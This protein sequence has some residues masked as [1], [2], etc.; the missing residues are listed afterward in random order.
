MT[1]FQN[2]HTKEEVFGDLSEDFLGTI[3]VR[4]SY[5]G[6]TEHTFGRTLLDPYKMVSKDANGDFRPL[7]KYLKTTYYSVHLLGYTYNI[8]VFPFSSQDGVAMKCAETA[9]YELCDYASA[10]SALY[11][12]VLPSDIQNTLEQRVPERIL[13]SRGLYCNDIS[14]ILKNFGFSPMIYVETPDTDHAHNKLEL[15]ESMIGLI[16]S[17]CAVEPGTSTVQSWDTE[18]CTS[19]RNWFHYYVESG[20]PLLIV[21]SPNQLV[22]KH[23]AL[24][25]GH[26]EKRKDINDCEIYRLGR[27]PCVD[28]AEFYEDY[29]V[30]DDNQIPYREEKMDHF[31]LHGNYR[32]DAFIVP[33]DR[34]V[35]LDASSAVSICDT[36][37]TEADETIEDVLNY[38]TD[39]YR[40][41][42]EKV[43]D[44]ED[45]R[46]CRDMVEVLTVSEENPITLRYYLANS[47]KYKRFRISSGETVEDKMFYA[48]VPMPKSVWV[49][50]I[51]TYELYK[52]GYALG[53]VVLDATAS[54]QSKLCG[55]ILFRT[56]HLGVYRLPSESYDVIEKGLE[57]PT[58]YES[59]SP[60]FPSFSNFVNDEIEHHRIE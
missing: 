25:I 58:D 49:A 31:T 40:E 13:P 24:V 45:K 57:G 16:S 28:T 7:L 34:H 55:I 5:S 47:A 43:E 56:G 8:R 41:Y 48:D 23:A 53:E 10:D 30:Q 1:T 37:I 17:S 14:F 27:F 21:T 52:M 59:L 26:G 54:N 32:L 51:S 60:I 20:I 22:N 4:P 39:F 9:I 44:D 29:I 36:Y 2:V 33:L 19:L 35:F 12:R 6:G 42:A 46:Q 11:A 3:V 38:L 18:H 50:E 15:Y